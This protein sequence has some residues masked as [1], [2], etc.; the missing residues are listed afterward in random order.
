MTILR[1]Q[2]RSNYT[3]IDNQAIR[4]GGLSLK[5]KGMLAVLLSLPDDWNFNQKGLYQ[6]MSD[7]EASI[8]SSLDELELHGYL[9]TGRERNI[10]GTLGDS[11]WIIR[12][13]PVLENQVLDEQ[14]LENPVLLNKEELNT[15]LLSKEGICAEKPKRR[16]FKAPSAEEVSEY[17][18]E[19][20]HPQ[21]NAAKFVDYYESI[22]WKVGK[23]PMKDWKAAVRG[24]INRD[25]PKTLKEAASA[26]SE[27][28]R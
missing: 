13:T 24:W 3:V 5:A 26:Y 18:R 11:V 27:Y 1:K 9:S 16:K 25:T 6:F 7:R 21:F 15:E 4:D 12:E 19:Y 2:L 22:G 10:D 8:R 28:N 23:N 17:A 14:V 20:G